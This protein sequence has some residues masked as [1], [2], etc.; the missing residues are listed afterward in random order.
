ME[1]ILLAIKKKLLHLED[2]SKGFTG[3]TLPIQAHDQTFLKGELNLAWSHKYMG[4]SNCAQHNQYASIPVLGGLKAC[5][6]EKF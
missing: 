1:T 2:I 3:L 5:P 6:P 4:L